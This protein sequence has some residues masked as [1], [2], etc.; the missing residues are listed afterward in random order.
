MTIVARIGHELELAIAGKK[1]PEIALGDPHNTA[2]TV[3]DEFTALDPAAN[4]AGA[5][6][7]ALRDLWHGEKFDSLTPKTASRSG[8]IRISVGAVHV[9]LHHASLQAAKIG[10][11]RTYSTR[12]PNPRALRAGLYGDGLKCPAPLLFQI[13]EVISGP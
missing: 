1:S 8:D 4:R 2:E 7:E 3:G 9:C 10:R 12:A 13:G 11:Q 6:V 5:H